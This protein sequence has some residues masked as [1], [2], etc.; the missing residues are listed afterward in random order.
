MMGSIDDGDHDDLM[1]PFVRVS[2]LFSLS[3]PL[4]RER[5]CIAPKR[6]RIY[7]SIYFHCSSNYE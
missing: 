2:V 1:C 3:V 7:T 5:A 6:G 4:S